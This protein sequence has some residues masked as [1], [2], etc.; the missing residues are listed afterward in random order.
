LLGD[1]DSILLKDITKADVLS[2]YLTNVNPASPTR[3]KLAV[4]LRSQ[5]PRPQKVSQEAMVA[6]EE[7]VTGAALG[8]EATTWRENFSEGSPT[9]TEFVKFW[10]DALTEGGVKPEIE[11]DLLAVIPRLLEEYPTEEEG[12]HTPIEGATYI[13]DIKHF[14]ASLKLTEPARPLVEWGDLPVPKL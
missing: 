8:F 2:L 13:E 4:H 7:K 1:E 12:D 5:K 3:A 6:F 11:Q 14:K 10:D 9:V